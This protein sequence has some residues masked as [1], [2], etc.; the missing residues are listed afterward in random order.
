MSESSVKVEGVAEAA[1]EMFAK[2]EKEHR[3]LQRLVGEWT[4]ESGEGATK[5]AGTETVRALGDLWVLGESTGQFP[6]GVPANALITLGY[7]PDTKRFVGT[8][9]GSMM[10]HLWIYDGE[11]DPGGRVLTLN[12]EGPSMSGDGTMAR[13]Q[14]IIELK[15]D[16]RRTLTAQVQEPD[17]TW[18][19]FMTMELRRR[20]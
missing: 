3:W 13:Y 8:W 15:S 19:Q 9:I 12:A 10:T 18:K 16:D 7:N 6:G 20:Q 5:A 11:L 2:P 14:D 4:Y 1:A 17:G